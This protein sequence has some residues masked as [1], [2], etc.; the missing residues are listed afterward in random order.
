[1]E[2]HGLLVGLV[3][4]KDLLRES[5]FIEHQLHKKERANINE[6]E[7]VLEEARMWLHGLY[8]GIIQGSGSSHGR[9]VVFDAEVEHEH[10]MHN[11]AQRERP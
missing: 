2:E 4:V 11:R 1:M 9:T 3:T 10:E 5:L 8:K 7:D 6:L